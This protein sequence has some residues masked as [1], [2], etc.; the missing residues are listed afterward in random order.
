MPQS[1]TPDSY[2][3]SAGGGAGDNNWYNYV[4]TFISH[5]S[6]TSSK[7]NVVNSS[8]TGSEAGVTIEPSAGGENFYVNFRNEG[9]ND[10]LLM[11]VDPDQNI[12]DPLNPTLSSTASPEDPKA[13]RPDPASRNYHPNLLVTEWIDAVGFMTVNS[14]NEWVREWHYGGRVYEPHFATG[15]TYGM[16]GLGWYGCVPVDLENVWGRDNNGNNSNKARIGGVW[17]GVSAVEMDIGLSHTFNQWNDQNL[18]AETPAAYEWAEDNN[19]AATIGFPKYAYNMHYGRGENGWE[20]VDYGTDGLLFV[21][22]DGTARQL[23]V[24]WDPTVNP[25]TVT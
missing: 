17:E 16:T 10:E 2:V 24:P 19:Q 21:C 15:P 8:D 5:L 22:Y 13:G 23:V 25:G 7:W 6:N 1:L 11:S 3:I 12:T 9:T 18:I 14:T 20:I 4:T